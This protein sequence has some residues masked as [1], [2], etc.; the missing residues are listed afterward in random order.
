MTRSVTLSAGRR[1]RPRRRTGS[2][3]SGVVALVDLFFILLFFILT[4]SS[5]VRI[6]GIKVDLPRARAPQAAGLGRAIV[7][8]APPAV[9]GAACRI[10]Y[11]DRELS[12]DE[13]RGELRK[14]PPAEKILVIRADQ[15]IPS[16]QLSKVMAIAE[17]TGI[18]TF[19]AVSEP[20]R[21]GREMRFE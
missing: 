8:I 17:E 21:G 16:G 3:F 19:I 20:K 9:P 10:Y 18:S 15:S 12:E 11:R 1:Y 2:Y 13:L 4:A 5:V 7:T 6:S 14:S